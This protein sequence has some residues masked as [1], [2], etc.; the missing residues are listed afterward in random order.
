MSTFIATL[1]PALTF[2]KQIHL[3]RSIYASFSTTRIMSYEFLVQVP[4][5]PNSLD[6]RLAARPT[7]LKNLK[8][9]IDSGKVVFGGATLSG[10]PKEGEAPDMTGSVMLIKADSQDELVKFLENDEYVKGGA[11]DIKNA[12]I[13][14]FRCAVRTAM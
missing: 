8:P 4:D 6:K 1:R 7:H 10:Q 12:K 3:K 9:H 11:W 13:T 5:F 2:S 14:P